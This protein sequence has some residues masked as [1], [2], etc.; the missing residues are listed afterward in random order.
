MTFE[1]IAMIKATN[2][3][4]IDNGLDGW[5]CQKCRGNAQDSAASMC[6]SRTSTAASH[7]VSPTPVLPAVVASPPF[8]THVQIQPLAVPSF[9]KREP[10]GNKYKQRAVRKVSPTIPLFPGPRKGNP[11]PPATLEYQAIKSNS[12]QSL[13]APEYTIE[14]TRAKMISERGGQDRAAAAP[15]VPCVKEIAPIE[16]SSELPK[17]LFRPKPVHNTNPKVETRQTGFKLTIDDSKCEISSATSVPS[18]VPLSIQGEPEAREIG[19]PVLRKADRATPVDSDHYYAGSYMSLSDHKKQIKIGQPSIGFVNNIET[20]TGGTEQRGSQTARRSVGGKLPR[21]NTGTESLSRRKTVTTGGSK[22]SGSSDH[23]AS[24]FRDLQTTPSSK[25]GQP[26][27]KQTARRAVG[28]KLP[29]QNTGTDS[30]ARWKTAATG[31]FKSSDSSDPH[32][33]PFRVMQTTRSSKGGQPSRKQSAMS[34]HHLKSIQTGGNQSEASQTSAVSDFEDTQAETNELSSSKSVSVELRLIATDTTALRAPS[35]DGGKEHR[36]RDDIRMSD[37]EE[38]LYGPSADF[39]RSNFSML[40]SKHEG[41]G[42]R[43]EPIEFGSTARVGFARH[44][45]E[46]ASW[47][48][49]AI[50]AAGENPA[51]KEPAPFP[52]SRSR[53]KVKARRLGSEGAV[54]PE[55]LTNFTKLDSENAA[56][57]STMSSLHTREPATSVATVGQPTCTRVTNLELTPPT[58]LTITPMYAP[59]STDLSKMTVP[60]LKALCKERGM[61]GYSKLSKLALLQKLANLRSASGTRP[62][63]SDV[64]KTKILP[65]IESS[66]SIQITTP[67]ITQRHQTQENVTSNATSLPKI[68]ALNTA[69]HA[70]FHEKISHSSATPIDVSS[71]VPSVSNPAAYTPQLSCQL[72][73]NAGS[74]RRSPDSQSEKHTAPKK[75]KTIDS[76]PEITKPSSSTSE[77]SRAGLGSMLAARKTPPT[78]FG[79]PSAHSQFLTSSATRI[80]PSSRHPMCLDDSRNTLT[81]AKKS[82]LRVS[83]N[84]LEPIYPIVKTH[85]NRFKPLLKSNAHTSSKLS[86]TTSSDIPGIPCT[87]DK[88]FYLEFPKLN[89]ELNELT[90]IT[91]PPKLAQRKHVDKWSIILSGL[92]NA[93][94]RQCILVSRTFRYAVYLS[95]IRLLEK[96]FYGRRLARMLLK[97]S[98]HTTNMWPYLRGRSEELEVIMRAYTQ[99]FLP[100][101]LEFS[102][103]ISQHLRTNP[104]NEKQMVIATRFILTR[105]WFLISTGGADTSALLKEVVV[106]AQE[107]VKDEIWSITVQKLSSAQLQTHHVLEPTCEI[108][109]LSLRPIRVDWWKY[110]QNRQISASGCDTQPAPLMAHVKWQNHEEY[111]Y[112][113]SKLWLKRIGPEGDYGAAKKAVAERYIIASIVGNRFA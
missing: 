66:A 101:C 52:A 55:E 47:M 32:A 60:Q 36:M 76:P 42:K 97:H 49:R 111:I 74:K 79:P 15:P 89:P 84:V 26:S 25:G 41:A 100:R 30:F 90:S 107:V 72:L 19:D 73:P 9:S 110:I 53:I 21:Q 91:L 62:V 108:I 22:S 6:P 75:K 65:S 2:E 54:D 20:A 14:I 50:G 5:V 58:L 83:A 13:Q 1:L 18:R 68:I 38:D 33:S 113:M 56:F 69:S 12:L 92:S 88:A 85:S 17:P 104:E 48:H 4:D 64:S 27:R 99:T 11:S 46:V 112:G 82:Q 44:I 103:P 77:D 39:F 102:L 80:V 63:P 34:K 29:R 61:S 31:G 8:G 87:A 51:S 67:D 24:P 59:P 71:S 10:K 78:A 96:K 105:L 7:P 98:Q 93:E 57:K 35:N 106:D 3:N 95:A 43:G 81:L 86:S 23:Y 16:A 45:D 28:G 37:S 70:L 109:G 40:S 94:R